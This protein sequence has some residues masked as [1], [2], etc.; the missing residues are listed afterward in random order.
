MVG[1]GAGGFLAVP[2]PEL[3]FA[4]DAWSE[5]RASGLKPR[6]RSRDAGISERVDRPRVDEHKRASWWGGSTAQH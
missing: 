2:Q 4:D 6:S 3:V 1:D 5:A